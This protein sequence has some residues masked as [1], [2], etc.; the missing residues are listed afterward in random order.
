VEKSRW[1]NVS[2]LLLLIVNCVNTAGAPAFADVI[3]TL[4]LA[5][6]W[7]ERPE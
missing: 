3:V 6:F 4:V 2:P 7:I 5:R 1:L